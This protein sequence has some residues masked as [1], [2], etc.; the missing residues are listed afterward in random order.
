VFR[1]EGRREKIASE[2]LVILK[3]TN[4][5]YKCTSWA[6]IGADLDPEGSRLNPGRMPPQAKMMKLN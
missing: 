4:N 3:Y 2:Y 5:T 6:L 1:V